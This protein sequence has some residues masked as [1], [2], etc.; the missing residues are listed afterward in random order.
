MRF[1]SRKFRRRMPS[2]QT[3][4]KFL[5]EENLAL[6]M[7]EKNL[8]NDRTLVRNTARAT[9]ISRIG[10]KRQILTLTLIVLVPWL[11][12]ASN[13]PWSPG[14]TTSFE[15]IN[16]AA[17][18]NGGTAIA[19]STKDENFPAI[20]TIDGDRKGLNWSD[21]GGWADGT[22]GVFPDTLEVQ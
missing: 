11:A 19:S 7:Q 3:M 22:P 14:L 20:S 8:D 12:S 16:V 1:D 15:R 17:A 9:S 4:R 2:Q 6:K 18:V 10:T 21:G 13:Q 5:E